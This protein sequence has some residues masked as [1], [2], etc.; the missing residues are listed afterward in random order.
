MKKILISMA[1]FSIIGCTI[2]KNIDL[3]SAN[4]TIIELDQ[5][6]IELIK[7]VIYEQ[8]FIDNIED[9]INQFDLNNLSTFHKIKGGKR[10]KLSFYNS[11]GEVISYISIVDDNLYINKEGYLLNEEDAYKINDYIEKVIVSN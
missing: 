4:Y 8:E 11:Q 9:M 6:P 5:K 3:S 2:Q 7:N 10:Y 1:L